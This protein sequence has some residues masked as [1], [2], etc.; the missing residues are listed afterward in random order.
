MLFLGVFGGGGDGDGGG[1]WCKNVRFFFAFRRDFESHI[2]VQSEE[3]MEDQA[4][5]RQAQAKNFLNHSVYFI[6]F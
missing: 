1:D 6:D 2:F 3:K 5:G 4:T